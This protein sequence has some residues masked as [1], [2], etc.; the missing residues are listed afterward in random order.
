MQL[1]MFENTLKKYK[2]QIDRGYC[3]VHATQGVLLD[4]ITQARSMQ[5]MRYVIVWLLRLILPSSS[6]PNGSIILPL[7]AEQPKTFSCL[8][9]Y[10]IEDIVDNFKFI[11]RNTPDI[12]TSTQCEEIV[13][14]C[15]VF[16][17][18]TYYIKNPHLKC[19]LVTILSHGVW[20]LWNRPKGVLGDLL[21]SM[22]LALEHLL[23]ALMNFYIEA[24]NTGTH[25]QFYDKFNIRYEIF[26]II[27]CIWSN[28][29]YRVH[30]ATEAK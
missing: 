15:I 14:I 1:S 28:P 5:F 13:T 10:F 24:E 6:Y 4:H 11:T 27:K 22:P 20:P 7:P 2:D 8:P 25:T 29:V 17:R 21:Q 12:I 23:H 26:Q 3:V 9:E 19:G 16:L 18:S 30:L